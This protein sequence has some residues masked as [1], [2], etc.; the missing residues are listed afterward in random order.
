MS[1]NLLKIY[2]GR[3]SFWQW[4]KGQQLV[5][6][7]D[8][9]TEVHLSHRGVNSSQELKIKQE[10]NMRICDIP[11][12]FL[13][14]SKNLVVYLVTGDD[15]SE[16]TTASVEIAVRHRSKPDGYISVHDN[17]YVDID[18]R[19]DALEKQHNIEATIDDNILIIK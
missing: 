13:Q 17:E 10:N 9:I 5:I 8:S 6:L 7:S 4:D 15:D 11:D 2:D 3:T 1:Q 19:L 12:V 16:H 18:C 14:I